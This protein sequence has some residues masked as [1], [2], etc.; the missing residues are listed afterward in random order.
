MNNSPLD[1][2]ASV[3]VGA[4]G[5]AA[6]FR[7]LV[8]NDIQMFL[9]IAYEFW[10]GFHFLR[11]TRRAVTVFGSARLP[12]N[13][14]FCAEA[15]AFSSAYAKKGFTII[16]GGGPSIMQAA[17]QGAFEAGGRSI[18]INIEIAREQHINPYV[19]AGLKC[20]YFFVRKV[21]LCRYSEAFV[22]FPGGFGTLDELLE[23]TTLMQ[24]KKMIQRP[25]IL[26]GTEFWNGFLSWCRTTL[27]A[28]KMISEAELARWVVV[29]NAEQAVA[30]LEVMLPESSSAVAPQP[31]RS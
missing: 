27:L 14:P 30:K 25:V 24:T 3:A 23:I 15:R 12:A 7:A 11:N 17:N 26:V 21:L 18:G 1:P 31:H 16:T 10:R 29:E 5:P 4:G 8:V 6:P 28:E 20:R 13:H 22:I 9:R 2:E 19:T